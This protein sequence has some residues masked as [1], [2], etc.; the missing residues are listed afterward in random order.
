M[1]LIGILLIVAGLFYA[2][3]RPWF[4]AEST[5]TQLAKAVVFDQQKIASQNRGWQ[6]SNVF[7]DK[8]NS[9]ARIRINVFRLPGDSY[10]NRGLKLL[11][12][13]APISKSGDKVA[14]RYQKS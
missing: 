10:D 6:V 2:I 4:G 12:R 3:A 13:V 7:L 5:T 9:P 11:V 8:A 14:A 1:R